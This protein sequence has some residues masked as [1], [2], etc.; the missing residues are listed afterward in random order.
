[1]AA[2]E[3]GLHVATI[4]TLAAGTRA[5]S[6]HGTLHRGDRAELLDGLMQAGFADGGVA[7]VHRLGP[8]ADE[9]HRDTARDA[10]A[11]EA[12]HGR[13]AEGATGQPSAVR[14]D[15][16]GQNSH[17]PRAMN[18]AANTMATTSPISAELILRYDSTENRGGAVP[19]LRADRARMNVVIGANASA[20]TSPNNASFTQNK[21]LRQ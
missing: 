2:R 18:A 16:P 20:N 8:V 12:A 13:A 21:A 7:A 17:A 6:A 19:R 5:D 14:T 9:P 10:G 3:G 4:F 15:L 1:M 11:L